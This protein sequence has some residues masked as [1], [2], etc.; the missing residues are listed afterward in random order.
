MSAAQGAA[1]ETVAFLLSKGASPDL[2]DN[3]GHTALV[4]AIHSKCSATIDLLAPVTKKALG[5]VLYNL[6]TFQP[7]LTP[8][9][10]ELLECAS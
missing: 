1:D 3:R 9:V 4:H 5:S 8:A 10:K 2:M 7:D 6:A